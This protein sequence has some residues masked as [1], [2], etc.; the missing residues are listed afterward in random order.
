MAQ[1]GM[2]NDLGWSP[3][4]SHELF[5]VGSRAPLSAVAV[6]AFT[7]LVAGTPFSQGT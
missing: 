3:R 6:W 2:T 1:A 4:R 7:V 5:R